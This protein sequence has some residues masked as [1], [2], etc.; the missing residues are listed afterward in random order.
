MLATTGADDRLSI[1]VRDLALPDGLPRA[2]LVYSGYSL[3]YLAPGDFGPVWRQIRESIRPGGWLAVNLLGDRDEWAGTPGE[4]FLGEPA[5]RRLVDGLEVVKF[6]EEDADGPAWSGTKHWH[7][8]H[9]IARSGGGL[10]PGQP[11]GRGRGR[12]T[13]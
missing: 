11:G 8:F 9:V 10:G 7:V 6:V 12:T 1:E 3:Q 13:D 5:V 2:D 4:T